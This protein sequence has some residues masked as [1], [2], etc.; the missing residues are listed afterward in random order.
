MLEQSPDW[1]DE[2]IVWLEGDLFDIEVE[3]RPSPTSQTVFDL[4]GM[5]VVYDAASQTLSACGS[6][7]ALAPADGTIRLRILLDR[8]SVEAYG[9]DGAVYIPYVDFPKEDNLR[10][11][12]TCDA[13][14]AHVSDLRV[15]QLE[16]SWK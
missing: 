12:A 3:F 1:L 8:T 15:H 10:M 9:N 2:W 5:K 14:E 13:G 7:T 11:S 6:T 4:R 16:S